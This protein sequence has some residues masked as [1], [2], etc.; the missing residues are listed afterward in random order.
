MAGWR[1]FALDED[2]VYWSSFS[3]YTIGSVSK[4]GGEPLI[5]F[6]GY[7][8]AFAVDDTRLYFST[9]AGENAGDLLAMPKTGG[10]PAPLFPGN[11]VLQVGAVAVDASC[12][13][14]TLKDNFGKH[15]FVAAPK[16][17][18]EPFTIAYLKAEFSLVA[19]DSSGVYWTDW[20]G[21]TVSML[22]K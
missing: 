3:T 1:A 14:W 19:A 13:Y 12:C 4:L 5:L 21:G 7:V 2:R 15:H 10:T 11:Q 20:Q 18:G 16:G 22:A 17:G 9:P 6:P 8:I